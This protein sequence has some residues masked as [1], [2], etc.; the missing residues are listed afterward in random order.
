LTARTTDTTRTADTTNLTRRT[1]VSRLACA[2]TVAMLPAALRLPALASDTPSITGRHSLRHHA[3]RHGL[4]A[5]AAVNGKLFATD[6]V[7]T[8]ILAEQYSL[9]VSEV[10]MK[11]VALRPTA[12]TFDFAEADRLLAFADQHHMK[13][14]GHTL[15]WHESI[16]SWF[17]ATVTAANARQTL[18]HHIAT[19][20]GHFKGRLHS[21]DVVNEAILP[22]DG[23]PDGLR[24]SPW[25]KLLG[26][27]Y[28]EIAF[29]AARQADPHVLL[30][31]NDYGVE[32]DNEEDTA[33]R[34]A[35]LQL[36]RRL[37][38]ANV[39]LDAVGIQSHI[40]AAQPHGF[41]NGLRE[42]MAAIRTMGLPIFLTELDVNEDDIAS[43][44]VAERDRLV[45]Q[46][47]RDFLAVALA[48][49]AVKAV[50]TWGVSDKHTWLNDGPTHHRKQPDRP[51]RSLPF[52]ADYHPKPA[53]F[54]L[55]DSFDQR[56]R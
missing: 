26:P 2:G 11:W 28:I 30:T 1:L 7:Y 22:K 4:L 10:A 47:Y 49:P 17:A 42:Y 33:R 35:I 53:Y 34:A 46:T 39:P 13:L 12:E 55:R 27:D 25:L 3:V 50:L 8:R 31:Y 19:V 16:P 56:P 14:R 15:V 37:K 32:V 44:D 21:W 20:V 36:L 6:P 52:D 40:K 38:A 18:E 48:E 54:A 43:N 23:R 9:L 41:G 29:R 24:D 45:A 51:Q 5:G